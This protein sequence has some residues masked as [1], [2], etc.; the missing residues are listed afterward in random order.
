VWIRPEVHP[1]SMTM[2]FQFVVNVF[3][4]V[5]YELIVGPVPTGR[6]EPALHKWEPARQEFM[7]LHDTRICI[8]YAAAGSRIW[9]RNLS[10]H[11]INAGT[12]GCWANR[13]AVG[14]AVP[15]T[16]VDCHERTCCELPQVQ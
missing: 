15:T 10:G 3:D 13:P 2:R 5:P 11:T 4:A 1:V 8:T 6:W 9:R 12:D 7:N 16:R 14:F